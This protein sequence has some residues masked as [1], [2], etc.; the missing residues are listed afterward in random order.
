MAGFPNLKSFRSWGAAW[1]ADQRFDLSHIPEPNSGCWLWLGAPTGS[2]GYGR[3]HVNGRTIGAHRYSW[4]RHHGRR[5]PAGMIILHTC[6]TPL[7][8]NPDHLRLG[9]QSE[10]EADKVAKGRQAKGAALSC[11]QS[12]NRPRGERIW[13]AKLDRERVAEI[14]GSNQTQRALAVAHGVSQSTI[15][16]I[17]NDRT[18]NAEQ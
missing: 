10:N 17:K 7:C 6:D 4:Q 1:P 3:L 14:R 16:Q 11:A 15:W 5:I 9:T 13:N 8:V 2:N 18:W 12:R